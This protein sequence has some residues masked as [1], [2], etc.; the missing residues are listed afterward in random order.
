PRRLGETARAKPPVM[1]AARVPWQNPVLTL[2][3]RRHMRHLGAFGLQLAYVGLLGV[4]FL[5]VADVVVRQNVNV[6]RTQ[7]LVGP[8]I[9]RAFWLTSSLIQIMGLGLVGAVLGACAFA[10]EREQRT[11]DAL[12]LTLLR[13]WDLL[14]GKS[15]ALLAFLVLLVFSGLPLLCLTF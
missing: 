14:L 8:R 7:P 13:P 9:G 10:V 4:I 15:A 3:L 6:G 1:R 2:A 12:W 11:S 5:I